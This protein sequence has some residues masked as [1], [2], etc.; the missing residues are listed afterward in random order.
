VINYSTAQSH[1]NEL[2]EWVTSDKHGTLL[3][4]V[5][6]MLLQ[7]GLI[8][9]L[10]YDQER[11]NPFPQAFTALQV[12]LFDNH[13]NGRAVK[14]KPHRYGIALRAWT[15]PP[16]QIKF[17]TT[18]PQFLGNATLFSSETLAKKIDALTSPKLRNPITKE[19][20]ETLRVLNEGLA[21]NPD[22]LLGPIFKKGGREGT[23]YFD[24]TVVLVAMDEAKVWG[25]IFA[26]GRKF[27]LAPF[28]DSDAA[29]KKLVGNCV[30]QSRTASVPGSMPK[31]IS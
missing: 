14:S 12:S 4:D 17:G 8:D 31:W 20:A 9:E 3:K 29:N 2:Q 10:P 24:E 28:V 22:F 30:L 16:K 25:R 11:P 5:R 26:N 21:I 15:K 19:Y 13:P 18:T 27:D 1:I 23:F 6:K 7:G